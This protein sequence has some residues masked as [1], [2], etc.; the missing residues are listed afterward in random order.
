MKK[1]GWLF[2]SISS[3]V[4][5]ISLTRCIKDENKHDYSYLNKYL[6]N[7]EF[8]V[9]IINK[10]IDT[11]YTFE[12]NG[13]INYSAYNKLDICY[14]ENDCLTKSVNKDG[15]IL[16]Y[17]EGSI[18]EFEGENRVHIF[19]NLEVSYAAPTH[20]I[21]I[22]GQKL[23]GT[24]LIDLSPVTT[25]MSAKGMTLKGAL[26]TGT[27]LGNCLN[28]NV[29]F[30]FGPKTS[31]GQTFDASSSYYISET[32]E[33]PYCVTHP[34]SY[35]VIGLT[36]GTLYHYRLK[37]INSNGTTY[38]G[39]TTF[40]TSIPTDP[41]SDID[42]NIYRTVPI[43]D[44]VWMAEN[45]K[46]THFNN[47][48]AIPIVPDN[49]EWINLTTPGYCWYNN[50]SANYKADYGALYN[51]YTVATGKLCPNGWHVPSG[52]DWISLSNSLGGRYAIGTKLQATGIAN[53]SG[54]SPETNV[55]GF[56]AVPSGYRDF[57]DFTGIGNY[58]NWWSATEQITQ[59]GSLVFY[60]D[61]ASL[62]NNDNIINESGYAVRCL[63]D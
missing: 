20:T 9:Y 1:T 11:S 31:Y 28:T 53:W 55:T 5:C 30:E 35:Y 52:D 22:S 16:D 7:W 44:Q 61:G 46:T 58:I 47:G 54:S 4:L 19:L 39:D 34:I 36:P 45:L 37:A 49:K 40:T 23:N 12:Y 3:V 57:G 8:K 27:V 63:K 48:T 18:G 10:R 38:G 6:G 41:V 17:S 15:K 43:G 42:G 14:S 29:N 2:L 21:D 51:W 25:T 13:V 32:P 33:S 26:L 50:D 56:T 62:S 59:Y 24:P 60:F